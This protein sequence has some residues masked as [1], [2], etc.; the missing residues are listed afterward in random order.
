VFLG[1]AGTGSPRLYVQNLDGGEARAISAEGLPPGYVAVS[2]DG[3]FVAARAPDWKIAIYP[4]DGGSSRPLPGGEPRENPILWSADGASLYT[5]TGRETPARAF[6]VDV[7]TGRRELWKTIAPADRSG[8]ISIDNIVITPD[9][10]SYAY[11]YQRILT[12]LE[13]VEGL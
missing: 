1:Y 6:K 7:A 9:A 12:S 4:I 8:L 2:P 3:R 5:Y 13:L 10:R 11:A